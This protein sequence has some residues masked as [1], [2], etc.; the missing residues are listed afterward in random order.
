[1]GN[2]LDKRVA[3]LWRIGCRSGGD[4]G[5]MGPAGG[6]RRGPA[7]GAGKATAPKTEKAAGLTRLVMMD[8][9]YRPVVV[10]VMPWGGSQMPRE[11]LLEREWLVTN[12]LGGYSSGTV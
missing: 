4:A 12:G 8:Q 7:I 9:T 2:H 5:R 11:S 3:F 6:I 1:M 10:R